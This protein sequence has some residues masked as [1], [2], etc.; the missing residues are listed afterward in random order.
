MHFENP[1]LYMPMQIDLNEVMEYVH[2]HIPITAHFKARLMN[3]DGAS[4]EVTAPLEANINHRNS[5]FGGSLSAIGILSGWA[6]L[7]IKMRE[8]GV[9]NKLV[10]QSSNFQFTDPVVSN[11]VAY[12]ELPTSDKYARF[13]KI[14]ERRGRARLEL[15]SLIRDSD[16]NECGSHI[17]EYVVIAG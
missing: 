9:K 10:I 1:S 15:R 2:E 11:F 4:L 7:F 12:V 13:L 14:L 5:A 17:G 3:Y 6:L 16:G 8:L